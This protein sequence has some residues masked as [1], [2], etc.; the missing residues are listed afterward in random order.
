MTPANYHHPYLNN[1]DGAVM[2]VVEL[3]PYILK[4]R[5]FPQAARLTLTTLKTSAEPDIFQQKNE[6][7]EGRIALTK[8]DIQERTYLSND[9]LK[10]LYD[11]LLQI[12]NWRLSRPYPES[13]IKDRM[14][15]D[16]N[17]RTVFPE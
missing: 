7:A 5:P 15:L 17:R 8:A 9:N 11:E 12:E 4:S 3:Q 13:I 1:L 6:L 16:L 10:A 2:R 14:W